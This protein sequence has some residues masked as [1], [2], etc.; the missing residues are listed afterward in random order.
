MRAGY[1]KACAPHSARRQKSPARV[2]NAEK[3]CVSAHL[4]YPTGNLCQRVTDQE[5]ISNE[6][7]FLPI[8]TKARKVYLN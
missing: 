4:E 5:V 8:A 7:F 1:S 3:T 6:V 2:K